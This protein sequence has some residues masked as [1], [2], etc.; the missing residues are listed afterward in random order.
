VHIV[1]IHHSGLKIMIESFFSFPEAP[2][3]Q[4][5]LLQSPYFSFY[6]LGSL[7]ELK[8]LPVI[9]FLLIAKARLLIQ[10]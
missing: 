1:R 3:A 2:Q 5:D 4:S 6:Q 8:R 7:I 9:F 10:L